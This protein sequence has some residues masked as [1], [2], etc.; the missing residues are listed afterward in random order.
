[1]GQVSTRELVEQLKGIG[2]E[3]VVYTCDIAEEEQVK[4]MISSVQETMPPI[5]GVL[6]GAMVIQVSYH[7]P[8]AKPTFGIYITTAGHP[9]RKV[10]PQ[11]LEHGR[12]SPCP[13]SLEPPQ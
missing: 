9:L 6:H 3:V 8:C 11:R 10:H 2:V 7:A 1:M 12:Q 5:R 13:R 4:K